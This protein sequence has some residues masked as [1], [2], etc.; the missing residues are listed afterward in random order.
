MHEADPTSQSNYLE[1]ATKHITFE[2]KVDFDNKVIAGTATHDLVAKVDG[3]SEVIFDTSYL[4]IEGVKVEGDTIHDFILGPKHEVMGAA[5]HVPL[6]QTVSVGSTISVEIKYSTTANGTALQFLEKEPK[7]KPSHSCLANAS[8]FMRETSHL[9]KAY[10]TE[11]SLDTPSVKLT[12]SASVRSV[13]PV[14]LSARRVS[15]P[16]DGP[17]HDGK[18]IWKDEV[19]YKY[20]QAC[21]TSL[22]SLLPSPTPIPS[23]LIAIAAGNLEYQPFQVPEG[24]QWTSGVWSEPELM[25]DS[26]WEFS[27][28]TASFLAAAENL[29]GQYRFG[30]YDLLVLPP[31]FPYGGMEN[32]CLT[33]VTPTLLA[34]DRSLTGVIVHELTHS[35]FG[36]GITHAHASHFWL[37][38]GW[39]TYIERVLLHI[40]HSPAHRGLS[41]VIGYKALLDSLALFKD[42]PKYQKLVIDFDYGENPDS[43]YSRVPYDKGAN[44]LLHI[45]RTLGGLDVFLP[46]VKD[47]IATYMGH[48]ITTETWKNHLYAYFEENGGEDKIKALDSINWDAWLHE[49]GLDLPVRMEYDLTLVNAA[50]ALADRWYES[51]L[52]TDPSKLDFRASDL[53][54]LD[55]NQRGARQHRFVISVSWISEVAA[56]FLERLEDYSEPLPAGHLFHFD[57]LYSFSTTPSTEIRFRFYNIVL[58]SEAATHFV[59]AAANWVIGMDD[60]GVI[61]GRMKF[62]R[63]VFRAIYKVDPGLARSTFSQARTQFHPIAQNLIAQDIG[64]D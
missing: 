63:P 39:T 3:V 22:A 57:Q 26:F 56:V 51:R 45:E 52:I 53:D 33:F 41:S 32:P 1:I 28:D 23:Y 50:Y 21:F 61:K 6:P 24:K 34:G 55:G 49:G 5:L 10:R 59:Q 14:L 62:C 25:A 38:E 30:V 44:F 8:P 19:I 11:Y 9:Y 17:A 43:A 42:K 2:W 40:I 64:L 18:V 46:Y 48:S 16:S 35:W 13:L 15:P 60:T 12:Y 4:H 29:A 20:D 37:N 36:N 7:E 54:S 47:Y 31:S 27:R 58:K